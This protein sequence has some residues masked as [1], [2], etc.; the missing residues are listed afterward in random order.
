MTEAVAAV[1][2]GKGSR[3]SAGVNV[4]PAKG[5]EWPVLWPWAWGSVLGLW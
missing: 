2:A 1:G 4:A 3:Q 5:F